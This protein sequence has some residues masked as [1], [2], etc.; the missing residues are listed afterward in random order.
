MYTFHCVW[1]PCY[2]TFKQEISQSLDR[3]FL[4]IEHTYKHEFRCHLVCVSE[5]LMDKFG[6]EVCQ[7]MHLQGLNPL[8]GAC[9]HVAATVHAH[10]HTQHGGQPATSKQ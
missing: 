2:A 1:V 7:S 4:S 10:T 9:V 6:V 5:N 8:H 3:R